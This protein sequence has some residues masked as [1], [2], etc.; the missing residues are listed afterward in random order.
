MSISFLHRMAIKILLDSSRSQKPLSFNKRPAIHLLKSQLLLMFLR[1]RLQWKTGDC[2][3]REEVTC[4]SI[5]TSQNQVMLVSVSSIS[6][7]PPPPTSSPV[8]GRAQSRSPLLWQQH[9]ILITLMG[10]LEMKE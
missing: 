5:N 9:F 7:F 1:Q 4:K 8:A 2:K 10:M 6:F 3:L